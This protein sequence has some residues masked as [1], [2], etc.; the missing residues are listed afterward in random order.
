MASL[1]GLKSRTQGNYCEERLPFTNSQPTVGQLLGDC[2]LAVIQQL[3]D[4]SPTAGRQFYLQ[5]AERI[6]A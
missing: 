5:F 2:Q 4:S 1:S 6:T 3:A